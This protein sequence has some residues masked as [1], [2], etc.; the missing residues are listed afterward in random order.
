MVYCQ[1]LDKRHDAIHLYSVT[2]IKIR[3]IPST[4]VAMPN[5]VGMVSRKI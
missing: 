2:N 3:Y 5:L 1:H 4:Y